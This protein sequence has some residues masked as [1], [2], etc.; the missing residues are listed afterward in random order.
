MKKK[1]CVFFCLV[2]ITALIFNFG[3]GS[4]TNKKDDINTYYHFDKKYWDEKDYD[5]VIYKIKSNISEEQK[6]IGL[7]DPL[8][9][10]V[11]KKLVDKENIIV[12]ANDSTLGLQHRSKFVDAMKDYSRTITDMY[13]GLNREDKYNYPEEYILTWKFFLWADY[14][15]IK[16]VNEKVKKES[17]A[18]NASE[19]NRICNYNMN[20]IINNFNLY[21]DL[22]NRESSFT[23]NALKLFAEGIDEC[24][25]NI[26][27][28]F[29]DADYSIILPKVNALL[30]KITSADVKKSL[31]NLKT[32]ID[33]LLEQKKNAATKK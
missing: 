19:A 29:P 24:F 22:V 9:A 11:F 16:I 17:D 33:S 1:F 20:V 26:I 10:P 28:T 8:K 31:E 7:S 12:V 2:F 30:Q 23:A 25:P 5:D 27:S 15:E 21:L 4:S 3:C 32:K 6:I 18:T 13:S 14:Y